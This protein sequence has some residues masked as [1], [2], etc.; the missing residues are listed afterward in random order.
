MRDHFGLRE[1]KKASQRMADFNGAG[2]EK[3]KVISEGRTENCSKSTLDKRVQAKRSLA[4]K[5]VPAREW[6]LGN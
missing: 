4:D 3:G 2:H 1:K 6:K 5:L